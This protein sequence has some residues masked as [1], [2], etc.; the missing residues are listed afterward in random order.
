MATTTINCTYGLLG[1]AAILFIKHTAPVG[2]SIVIFGWSAGLAIL[3]TG[4]IVS[5]IKE[6]QQ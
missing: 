5:A 4:Q 2:E 6:R 1:I 3:L